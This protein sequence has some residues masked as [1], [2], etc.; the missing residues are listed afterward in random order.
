MTLE[1][2]LADLITGHFRDTLLPGFVLV[3]A[4]FACRHSS[5]FQNQLDDRITNP[6][7]LVEMA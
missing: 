3:F 5:Q 7:R 2:L 4:F 1:Y 6:L